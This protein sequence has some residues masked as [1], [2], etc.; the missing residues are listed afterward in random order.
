MAPVSV[1]DYIVVHELAHLVHPNHSTD[2]WELVK[3][4]IPDY[5]ERQ[6]WL[7]VNGNSLS[8]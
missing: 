6:E 5:K 3:A 7:K 2:F 1:I 8:I 4:I